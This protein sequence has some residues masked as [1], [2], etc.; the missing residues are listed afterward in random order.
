MFAVLSCVAVG[1]ECGVQ[2]VACYYGAV[3]G[4]FC[5]RCRGAAFV[6]EDAGAGGEGC[7]EGREG[8]EGAVE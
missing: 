7:F 8:R 3:E 4:V 6:G 5:E 2:A 1:D